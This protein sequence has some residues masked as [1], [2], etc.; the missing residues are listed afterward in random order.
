MQ[1]SAIPYCGPAAVPAGFWAAWNLDPW[2]LAALGGLV[3]VHIVAYG[4]RCRTGGGRNHSTFAAAWLVLVVA[5]VSPLCALSVALFSARVTHHLLLVGLA[6]PLLVIAW[7]G[8]FARLVSGRRLVPMAA[9]HVALFWFWH[10][11]APYAAALA[12]V[13]TYWAMELSLFLSALLFWTAAL[14]RRASTAAFAPAVIGVMAQMGVIGAL[15]VFAAQPLYAAHEATTWPWGLTPLAD[16]QLAGLIMWVPGAVPY[17]VLLLVRVGR[18]LAR[19]EA[20]LAR[21]PD[22]PLGAAAPVVRAA[23][24]VTRGAGRR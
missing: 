24:R 16:Q 22:V 8:L 14:D 3:A 20:E 10:A 15:L 23:G 4:Q 18:L 21:Q 17:L 19:Q 1:F 5:F 12:S 11:P 2:L 9:L 13:G 7:R 6:A